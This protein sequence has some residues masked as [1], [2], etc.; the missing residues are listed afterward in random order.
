MNIDHYRLDVHDA[1]RHIELYGPNR[2]WYPFSE[3]G[4]VR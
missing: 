4:G 1:K 2:N 3:I